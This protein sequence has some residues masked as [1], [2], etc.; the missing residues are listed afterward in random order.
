MIFSSINQNRLYLKVADQILDLI[1]QKDFS[2]GDKLPSERILSSELGVS[3]PTVR[4][5][6]VAL[7]LADMIEIRTA[8]GIYLK[9]AATKSAKLLI[10][11]GPGPFEILEARQ[12]FEREACALAAKRI[13]DEQLDKLEALLDAMLE[14]NESLSPTE[15]ADEEFHCEIAKAS[16]NSAIYQTVMWLWQL[17]NESDLVSHFHK[18]TRMDGIRPIIEDHKKI[19]DALK[20]RDTEKSRAAMDEHLHRVIESLL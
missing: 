13:S 19:L 14:E 7:E 20:A 1:K 11:G 5:A 4:E 8:S 18:Q 10:D 16:G 12:I 15:K 3:R 9:H 2:K 17:R 6:M